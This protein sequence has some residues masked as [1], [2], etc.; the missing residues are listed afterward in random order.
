MVMVNLPIAGVDYHVPF[1]RPA[2]DRVLARVNRA[3][4]AEFYTAVKTAYHDGRNGPSI[5]LFLT[6]PLAGRG[7][8]ASQMR[9]G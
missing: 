7:R 4:R 8:I 1:R 6:R 3:L 9:S 2:R 5:G